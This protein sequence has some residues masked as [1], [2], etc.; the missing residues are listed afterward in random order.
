MQIAISLNICVG[1]CTEEQMIPRVSRAGFDA[2]DFNFCDLTNRIDW[3]DQQAVDTLLNGWLNV[4]QAHNIGWI[5]AHG[6]M[7]SFF[8]SDSRQLQ[9]RELCVPALHACK[10]LGVRWMVLHPDVF[11]GPFDKVH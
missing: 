7:F 8:S 10:R 11:A 5:Q 6:P 1:R 4:A 3:Y 9:L 2:M